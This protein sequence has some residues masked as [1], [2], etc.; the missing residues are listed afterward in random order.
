MKH[1]ASKYHLKDLHQE[2]D[3]LDR[4]LA[5]CR[6]H[7]KFDSGQERD[8]ALRKLNLRRGGL[9]KA[10]VDLAEKGVE[11]DPTRLPRSLRVTSKAASAASPTPQQP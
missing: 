7:E 4:K 3:Y 8:T 2:I 11:Y 1:P 5:Y 6:D 10:A 9:V